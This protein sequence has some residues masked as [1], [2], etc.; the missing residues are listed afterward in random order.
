MTIKHFFPLLTV[1]GVLPHFRLVLTNL[2]QAGRLLS[3]PTD[4]FQPTPSLMG[5]THNLGDQ[6][7]PDIAG[8]DNGEPSYDEEEFIEANTTIRPSL[9]SQFADSLPHVPSSSYTDNLCTPSSSLQQPATHPQ[10]CPSLNQSSAHGVLSTGISERVTGTF[11][12]NI[13]PESSQE[14]PTLPSFPT[15]DQ[16]MAREV[17]ARTPIPQSQV[18]VTHAAVTHPVNRQL[19]IAGS[20]QTP[21]VLELQ[22]RLSTPAHI[23]S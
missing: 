6:D 10:F 19:S 4:V 14:L 3:N 8:V 11:L 18:S 5:T 7:D 17:H 13:L 9:Y 16:L 22:R 2:L 20:S 12:Q 21:E 15:S 1:N 23:V